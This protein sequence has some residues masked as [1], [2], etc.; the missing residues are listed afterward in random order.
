MQS[1]GLSKI[2]KKMTKKY[3]SCKC[4]KTSVPTGSNDAPVVG[5]VLVLILLALY[6][7][8][9]ISEFPSFMN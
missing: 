9:V 2:I 6:F 7:T 8:I 4:K 3:K 5:A 1:N